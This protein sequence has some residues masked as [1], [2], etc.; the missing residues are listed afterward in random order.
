MTAVIEIFLIAS[1]M[2]LMTQIV[3]RLLSN[4]EQMRALSRKLKDVQK[5]LLQAHK[6]GDSKQIE[7]LKKEQAV[8]MSN[9]L[10]SYKQMFKPMLF[11]F[12]PV[13]IV[14]K[15]IEGTYSSRGVLVTIPFFGIGLNWLWTYLLSV[16]TCSLILDRVLR[17]V[18]K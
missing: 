10:S 13:I 16:I 1:G 7:R 8:H 11:T 9:L 17:R 14:F 12:I 3:N 18:W 15:L 5:E 4:P 2:A 6:E